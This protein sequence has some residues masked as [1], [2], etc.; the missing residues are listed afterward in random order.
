MKYMRGVRLAYM[1]LF[2]VVYSIV[3]YAVR[4]W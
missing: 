1:S 2:G 4:V 3:G